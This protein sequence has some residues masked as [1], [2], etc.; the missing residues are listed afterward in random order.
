MPPKKKK[1]NATLQAFAGKKG[2]ISIGPKGEKYKGAEV[3][4]TDEIYNG[5]I[6][7]AARGKL[8]LYTVS[9]FDT[10][11][12]KYILKYE[13]KAINPDGDVFFAFDERDDSTLMIAAQKK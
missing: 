4:M 2:G 12:E 5:K 3:L 7:E 10:G 9:N 1:V 8:F 6:P 13:K 11:T